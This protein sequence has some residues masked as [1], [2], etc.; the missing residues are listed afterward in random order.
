MELEEEK[1]RQQEEIAE[2]MK[3]MAFDN[4]STNLNSKKSL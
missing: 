1:N 3:V 4:M 2:E